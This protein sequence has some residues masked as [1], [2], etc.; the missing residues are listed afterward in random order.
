MP[1]EQLLCVGGPLHGRYFWT[2]SRQQTFQAPM[3][4]VRPISMRDALEPLEIE[5][6]VATYHKHTFHFP[7]RRQHE[8][9]VMQVWCDES[10]YD[11]DSILPRLQRIFGFNDPPLSP[12]EIERGIYAALCDPLNSEHL[13]PPVP[14]PEVVYG[15]DMDGMTLDD[16]FAAL[17]AIVAENKAHGG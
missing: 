1:D 12:L 9:V 8:S 13:A 10:T 11:A 6:E 7:T 15:D 5:L 3:L 2:N 4:N 17:A 14:Q 16:G